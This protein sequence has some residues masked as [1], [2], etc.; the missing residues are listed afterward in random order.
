MVAC[1]GEKGNFAGVS[2]D[3]SCGSFSTGEGLGWVHSFLA[4]LSPLSLLLRLTVVSISSGCFPSMVFFFHFL[5]VVGGCRWW[6]LFGHW[7]FRC[8]WCCCCFFFVFVSFVSFVVA[9]PAASVAS[10]TVGSIVLW[11]ACFCAS[12][13]YLSPSFFR[14]VWMVPRFQGRLNADSFVLVVVVDIVVVA[15]DVVTVVCICFLWAVSDQV[16]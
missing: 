1:C 13:G 2:Y 3:P 5:V 8:C 7:W 11:V 12:S 4:W 6:R 10:S 14:I 9:F 15:V 16:A